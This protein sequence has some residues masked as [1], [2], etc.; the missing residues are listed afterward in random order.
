[1]N[2]RDFLR[3]S[4]LVRSA[5]QVLAALDE[6]SQAV[7]APVADSEIACLRISRRAMATNFEVLVPFGAAAALSTAEAALDRIDELE[8]QLTVYQTDSEISRLN[9]LAPYQAVPVESGLF[10]LLELAARIHKELGGS[11]DVAMGALIKAWGFFRGPRRVPEEQQRIDAWRKGGMDQVQLDAANQTVRFLCPGL[12]INLGSIGKGYAIDRASELLSQGGALPAF[13]LHGGY[14]SL[15]AQ[16]DLSAEARG[17][18]VSI[19]HPWIPQRQLARVWLKDRAL[20]TSAATFQYLEHEGRKLG[21][22]L[23]PRTGWP[24]AGVAS[25][26]VLAPSSAEADALSTAFFILG[27][28]A[29]RLY[30]ESHPGIDAVLLPDGDG[31]EP[32]A[33]GHSS[34][35]ITL[36]PFWPAR[37]AAI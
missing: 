4:H 16:G 3:S 23:D 36:Q 25:A 8:A 10:G 21:H 7:S 28:D 26:T 2:R 20:G 12:E 17:W 34:E 6:I 18:P 22:L 14:S 19:A 24:A 29:A 30:C 35:D 11:F 33:F 5:G 9:S 27:V 31:A 37:S 13:L 1:M 32:V 15:Y